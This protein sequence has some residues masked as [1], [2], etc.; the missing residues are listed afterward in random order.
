M[1]NARPGP[2]EASKSVLVPGVDAVPL[3]A[4]CASLV[5]ALSA[6]AELLRQYGALGQAKVV[7]ASIPELVELAKQH[8]QEPLSLTQA[9]QESG[10]TRDHLA[11]RV[12]KG[13]IPNAGSARP[14]IRRGD[15]PAKP[16][17]ANPTKGTQLH[18]SSRQQVARSSTSRRD[19]E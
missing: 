5:A 12:R 4:C 16:S 10:F 8:W 18:V 2:G 19:C 3:P 14:L 1:R 11:R 13:L 6:R 17:L 7:E 9:A 15:L